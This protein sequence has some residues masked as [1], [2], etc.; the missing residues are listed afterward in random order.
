[1]ADDSQNDLATIGK[2]AKT[3]EERRDALDF[4]LT[5]F[6]LNEDIK[7]IE[8]REDQNWTGWDMWRRP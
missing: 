6:W 7:R 4:C 2:I 8:R 5:Q 3:R 1:M